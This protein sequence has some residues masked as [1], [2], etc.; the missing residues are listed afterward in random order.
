MTKK[1]SRRFLPTALFALLLISGCGGEAEGSGVATAGDGSTGD[2]TKAAETTEQPDDGGLAFAACM[3]EQGID[4]PDPEPGGERLMS[5]DVLDDYDRETI[6][7]GMAECEDLIPAQVLE[8]RGEL[9]E[10]TE[11]ALAECLR[12]QGIDVPDDLFGSG[13]MPEGVD[14]DELMPAMDRCREVLE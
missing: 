4:M 8:R 6:E 3:R 2:S 7:A 1:A 14:R 10:E 11:L 9:D 13:G 12:E 5:P